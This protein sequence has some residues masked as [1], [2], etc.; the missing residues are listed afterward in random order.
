MDLKE[1]N[2]IDIQENITSFKPHNFC[3]KHFS[4]L[5]YFQR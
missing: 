1:T 5:L 2:I 3:I 4:L